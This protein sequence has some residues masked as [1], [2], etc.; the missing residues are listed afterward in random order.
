VVLNH[1][2]RPLEFELRL[3]APE[4]WSSPRPVLRATLAPR[5]ESRFP[6]ELKPPPGAA[7][8]DVLTAS[9]RLAGIELENYPECL[10]RL[11]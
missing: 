4:G 1:A 7:G 5:R 6:L 2:A 3:K 11:R 9:V 8:L 10:V